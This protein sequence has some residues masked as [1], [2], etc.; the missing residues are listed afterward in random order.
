MDDDGV[1]GRNID[2]VIRDLFVESLQSL[3]RGCSG[4]VGMREGWNPVKVGRPGRR[5]A[6]RVLASAPQRTEV[7]VPASSAQTAAREGGSEKKYKE[8]LVYAIE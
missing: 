6:K 3:G 2:A 4:G 8:G 5:G 7:Q 1:E